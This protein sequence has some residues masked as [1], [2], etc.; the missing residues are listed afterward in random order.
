ME[1]VLGYLTPLTFGTLTMLFHFCNSMI[2]YI[3]E[4]KQSP[5]SINPYLHFSTY[6]A[7]IKTQKEQ[8]P[9]RGWPILKRQKFHPFNRQV[10]KGGFSMP[11]SGTQKKLLTIISDKGKQCENEHPK[12][13]QV[14]EIEHHT[15]HLPSMQDG[16]PT[17]LQCHGYSLRSLQRIVNHAAISKRPGSFRA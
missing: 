3:L 6:C 12:R 15:H 17:P 4:K 8:P 7:I 14:F 9:A 10:Y 16:R 11:I 2:Q 13:H 5:S 1:N